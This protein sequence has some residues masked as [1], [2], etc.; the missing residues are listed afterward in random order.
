MNRRWSKIASIAAL[1][2]LPLPL[3]AAPASAGT[4]GT[5]FVASLDPFATGACTVTPISTDGNTITVLISAE[6]VSTYPVTAA[7]RVACS[8]SAGGFAAA[9]TPGPASAA[10]G[11]ATIPLAPFQTCIRVT[12]FLTDG[13]TAGGQ[14]FCS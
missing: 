11:T 5:D 6:G 2:L 3:M 12:A 8:L 13:T 7:T 9:T 14:L 10:V 1:S 4:A